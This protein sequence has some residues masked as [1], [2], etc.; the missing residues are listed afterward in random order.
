MLI[1]IVSNIMIQVIAILYVD[2]RG[3]F[4]LFLLPKLAAIVFPLQFV[5]CSAGH[6]KKYIV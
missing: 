5:Q 3:Q 1:V 2:Q 4:D 6:R